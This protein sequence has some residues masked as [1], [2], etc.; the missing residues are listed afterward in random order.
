MMRVPSLLPEIFLT[1]AVL[2][3]TRSTVTVSAVSVSGSSP[4]ARVTW[5][6]I[7]PPECVTSVS[8][9]F[10]ATSNGVLVASNT[11]TNISATEI[12]QTGLQCGVSYNIRVVV[13]GE[14]RYQGVPVEQ[15]LFSSQVRLLI[16]GKVSCLH[17]ISVTET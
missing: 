9:N 10:R 4:G 14:P 7:V 16:R 12:I 11:T 2:Q 3:F 8:V 15:L 1:H 13:T 17:E 5:R 6:M